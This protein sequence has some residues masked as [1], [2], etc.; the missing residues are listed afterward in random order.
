[1]K[2]YKNKEISDLFNTSI[3]TLVTQSTKQNHFS[4]PDRET[5][6]QKCLFL[7]K[8]SYGGY[9][10]WVLTKSPGPQDDERQDRTPLPRFHPDSHF[11]RFSN[12]RPYHR[13]GMQRQI[14]GVSKRVSRS[15]TC[16]PCPRVPRNSARSFPSIFLQ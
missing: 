14:N 1:M 2:H 13:E 9:E 4:F 5:C 15:L 7:E 11:P 8:G 10:I 16:R 12:R 3:L 6:R